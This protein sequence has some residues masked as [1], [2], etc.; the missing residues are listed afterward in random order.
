MQLNPTF[1]SSMYD[2]YET[3]G[4]G[5]KTH[6]GPSMQGQETLRLTNDLVILHSL[7]MQIF[8]DMLPGCYLV[9]VK[10]SSSS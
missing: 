1:F 8:F 7:V 9:G 2:Q 3:L 6:T 5:I 4:I 10:M